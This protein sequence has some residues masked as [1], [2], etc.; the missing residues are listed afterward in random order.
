M[1]YQQVPQVRPGDLHPW[2]SVRQTAIAFPAPHAI[3]Q[4]SVQPDGM[5]HS[6][7]YGEWQCL[8]LAIICNSS[9]P[10]ASEQWYWMTALQSQ[11]RAANRTDLHAVA[12][13]YKCS[14]LGS[15]VCKN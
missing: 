12:S 9:S 15:G 3:M 6:N 14:E 13:G 2:W 1:G 8:F 7:G 10:S 11:S 4:T 5:A